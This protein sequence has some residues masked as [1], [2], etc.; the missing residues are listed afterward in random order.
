MCGKSDKNSID[1][2]KSAVQARLDAELFLHSVNVAE[3]AFELCMRHCP[4]FAIQSQLAGLLHDIA[5]PVSDSELLSMAREFGILIVSVEQI[6]PKLLHASV[7][8]EI[9][10]REFG[11]RDET[12]LDAIR[13]HTVGKADLSLCGISLYLADIIEPSRDFEGVEL[14]RRS[15][16]ESLLEGALLGVIKTV[17]FVVDSHRHLDYR[18]VEFYNWLLG[19]CSRV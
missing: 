12:I 5:K 9:A 7:G 19:E 8:A 1:E 13:W 18:S 3:T 15:A 17:K 11:V 6:Q 10:R 4:E 2:L 16:N 14:I